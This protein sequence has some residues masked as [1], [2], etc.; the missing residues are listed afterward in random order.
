MQSWNAVANLFESMS[1][2][3]CKMGIS[4]RCKAYPKLLLHWYKTYF[5]DQIWSSLDWNCRMITQSDLERD[6]KRNRKHDKPKVSRVRDLDVASICSFSILRFASCSEIQVSRHSFFNSS[7][8]PPLS[9]ARLRI[10]F[11]T[12]QPVAL[13][14]S[15]YPQLRQLVFPKCPIWV[16][17]E[18]LRPPYKTK[19]KWKC[20]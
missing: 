7:N 9:V 12:W 16:I 13:T 8:F 11:D 6:S 10:F 14:T 19:L 2:G 15:W 5:I 3:N 1:P 20:A 4:R 17:E 18:N